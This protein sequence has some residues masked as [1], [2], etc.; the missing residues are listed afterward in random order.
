MVTLQGYPCSEERKYLSS[1][2]MIILVREAVIH[3][4]VYLGSYQASMMELLWNWGV[5]GLSLFELFQA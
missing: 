1:A 4:E 5:C 2:T 3:R